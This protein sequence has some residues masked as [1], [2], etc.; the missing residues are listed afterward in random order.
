MFSLAPGGRIGISEWAGSVLHAPGAL[1]VGRG[2][3]ANF[4]DAR[5]QFPPL[6]LESPVQFRQPQSGCLRRCPLRLTVAC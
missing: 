1:R 2:G 6:A 4:Q 5:A 3:A